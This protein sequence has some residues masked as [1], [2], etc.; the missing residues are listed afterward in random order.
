M[1]GTGTYVDYVYMHVDSGYA[2]G[3]FKLWGP[4]GF[5]TLYSPDMNVEGGKTIRFSFY[6][7]LGS[8]TYCTAFQDDYSG[9]WDG[10]AC[11]RVHP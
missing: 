7:Y 1:V 4:R 10:N 5:A 2:T 11:A 8:G 3:Y 6:R 9:H